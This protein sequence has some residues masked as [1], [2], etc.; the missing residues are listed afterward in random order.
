MIYFILCY[1]LLYSLS[2][3]CFIKDWISCFDLK[4]YDLFLILL[5]S[6]MPLTGIFIGITSLTDGVIGIIVIRRKNV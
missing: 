6:I 4:V 2:V 1:V 5:I 3:Y